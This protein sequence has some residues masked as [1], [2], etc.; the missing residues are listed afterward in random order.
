MIMF[1]TFK[2][3]ETTASKSREAWKKMKEVSQ[4]VK[5]DLD[6]M[7]VLTSKLRGNGN[8]RESQER[9]G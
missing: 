1:L 6:V 4:E 2:L 7:L 3:K 9:R 8:V 5:D